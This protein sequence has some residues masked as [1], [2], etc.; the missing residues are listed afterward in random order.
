MKRGAS[1][2]Q[3]AWTY[4]DGVKFSGDKFCD[5]RYREAS[6]QAGPRYL[7]AQGQAAR[8]PVDFRSAGAAEDELM[9]KSQSP[10]SVVEEDLHAFVGNA[11]EPDHHQEVQD[12]LNRNSDTVATVAD[13]A[14]QRQFLRSGLAQSPANPSRS[15]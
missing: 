8:S 7:S 13:L 11:L 15:A 4:G 1:C 5:G 2:M 10:A 3:V 12:F 6:V 9:S 14:V